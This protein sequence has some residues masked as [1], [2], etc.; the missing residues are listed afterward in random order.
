[1]IIKTI[2][3]NNSVTVE[4]ELGGKNF[5][6]ELNVQQLNDNAC[7]IDYTSIDGQVY[8]LLSVEQSGLISND[9]PKID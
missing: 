4:I 8:N 3:D 2:T 9:K 5:T 6:C 1:M 7:Y